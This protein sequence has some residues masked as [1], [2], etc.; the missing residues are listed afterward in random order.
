MRACAYTA[1][2]FFLTVFV[3]PSSAFKLQKEYCSLMWKC[4]LPHDTVSCPDS[5]K[6]GVKGVVYDS[7]RCREARSL[8]E[9]GISVR[10]KSGR[11]LYGFLG[12]KYRVEY[13]IAS[14]LLVKPVRFEYLLDDLPL[15]ARL[16][17]ASRKTDY[18]V[19]YL[20]GKRKRR[21]KG[22]KG[23]NLYGEVLLIT[24]SISEKQLTYF[25]YGV[26]KIFK[27]KLKGPVLM[28]F[29]YRHEKDEAIVYDIKVIAAPGNAMLNIIMNMS[30]FKFVVK[31]KIKEVLED[32]TEA[33]TEMDRMSYED[34]L[35]MD[36]WSEKD[37]KKIRELVD[38]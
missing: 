10:T 35:K 26:A 33:G 11:K 36:D 7:I 34:I 20:D 31:H 12:Y 19:R 29:S 28:D 8:V 5:L 27:W 32:I 4:G 37:K 9:K 24:G 14:I 21:F 38:L 2:S 16:V 13:P 6:A 17:N 30:I 25:G 3:L 18:K 15:A 22:N 1:L 23:K